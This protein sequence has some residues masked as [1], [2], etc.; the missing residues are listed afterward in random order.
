MSPL[1]V[2]RPDGITPAPAV[3]FSLPACR[4]GTAD[5]ARAIMIRCGV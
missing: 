2:T 3:G 5:Y 1:E 4:F